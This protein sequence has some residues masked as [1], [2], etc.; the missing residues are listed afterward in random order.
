MIYIE[1][2]QAKELLKD[3]FEGIIS[4]LEQV[5]VLKK[6]NKIC[7]PLKPYLKFPEE[8]NR[9]I[10]MP[11]YVGGNI[12]V[13]GI[14]WISSFPSNIYSNNRRANCVTVVNSTETGEPLCIINSPELS[15]YRT[16]SVSGMILKKYF[17]DNDYKQVK[18]GIIGY[19]PI[20][21]KH[22]EMCYILF[23]EK[24]EKIYLYDL[25][26]I[27]TYNEKSYVC[28]SWEEVYEQS[29]ILITCTTACKPYLNRTPRKG[30]LTMNVSLRDFDINYINVNDTTMLIDDWCEINREKTNIEQLFQSGKIQE[31]DCIDIYDYLYCEKI[32][33]EKALFFNPMGLAIF[34]VVV[35]KYMYEKAK[36]ENGQL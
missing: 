27:D 6:E 26:D 5:V 3:S 21:K 33:Y 16:A 20:G 25:R 35:G 13:C 4:Q 18:V 10:A 7:Q 34:D 28:N 32:N 9:I 14:K 11:A 8:Q 30:K 19:G 12:N 31:N 23:K 17:A 2:E 24:I 15:I 29:D 36:K 1:D 22:E